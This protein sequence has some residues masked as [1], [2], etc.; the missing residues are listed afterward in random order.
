[1]MEDTP[2]KALEMPGKWLKYA[3]F[4]Y[5]R[6]GR[7]EVGFYDI[8]AILVTWV[9]NRVAICPKGPQIEEI[10]ELPDDHRK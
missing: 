9:R 4:S 6:T 7:F 2:W 3:G 10:G 5:N 8:G 1:M